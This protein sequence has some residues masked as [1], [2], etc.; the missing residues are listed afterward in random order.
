M[1]PFLSVII[2]VYN[3]EKYLECCLDSV[4]GQG[5]RD[6][7]IILVDDGST[8]N[9]GRICDD[10]AAVNDCITVIHKENTGI[11]GARKAGFMRSEGKYI[12]F[13]DSDD[14]VSPDMF[15]ILISKLTESDADIVMCNIY[16]EAVN[17]VSLRRNCIEPGLYD[18][19]AIEEK[20]FPK[21]FVGGR[22]GS[23]G[24]IPSLCNKIIRREIIEKAL[25]PIDDSVLFGEDTL[26]TVQG[27]LDSQRVYSVDEVLYRYRL[28][29]TSLTNVYDAGLPGKFVTL[30][31]Y[32]D[33]ILESNGVDT[34]PLDFYATRF[35]LE[36]IR[37]ELLYNTAA[38]LKERICTVKKFVA[39]PRMQSAI[40]AVGKNGFG[41]KNDIKIKLI[42][43][44][45]FLLLY[46][47]YSVKK[48]FLGK[49]KD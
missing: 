1:K 47:F 45:R 3:T 42:T 10:Y 24:I 40:N 25:M 22:N 44:E 23:P 32:L 43:G 5:Y 34:A 13:I 39:H 2:P 30:V 37:K 46:I 11:T 33:E 31:E 4:L 20:I 36:C 7:E 49:R 21:L 35:A 9:S 38:S 8:D 19:K 48:L 16:E 27:F 29:M 26:C 28:V 12:S 15:E 41:D 18:R 6:Y 17:K 14:V